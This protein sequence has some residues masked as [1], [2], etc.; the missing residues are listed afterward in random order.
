MC[1]TSDC[2]CILKYITQSVGPSANYTENI[3]VE[4]VYVKEYN[5]RALHGIHVTY[6]PD[7]DYLMCEEHSANTH[8]RSIQSSAAKPLPYMLI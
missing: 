1:R 7:Y 2:C 3:I 6:P 5:I 8:C 4:I